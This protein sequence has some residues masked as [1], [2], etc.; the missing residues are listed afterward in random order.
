MNM[1][2]RNLVPPVESKVCSTEVVV[3]AFTSKNTLRILYTIK[4]VT[5]PFAVMVAA[6]PVIYNGA[7]AL[8]KDG[9]SQ[10]ARG[11]KLK[12]ADQMKIDWPT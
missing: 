4:H 10:V 2:C 3:A 1:I 11:Y 6:R 9:T 5:R 12:S 8:F 7:Q